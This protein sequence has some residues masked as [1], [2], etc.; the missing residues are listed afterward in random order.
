MKFLVKVTCPHLDC[1]TSSLIKIPS[2][3]FENKKMG[4]IRV[5][6]HAG[7]CCEH[8]FIAFVGKL[9]ANPPKVRGYETIDM[10]IDLSKFIHSHEKGRVYLQDLIQIY[11][12]YAISSC[13]H[14]LMLDC[15]IMFLRSENKTNRAS[16]IATLFNDF[17]PPKY[18]DNSTSITDILEADYK[19]AKINNTLVINPNGLI[20][21]LPWPDISLIFEKKLIQ[22]ALAILDNKLQAVL[23][24][25]DIDILFEKSIFISNIIRK[26]NVFEEDLLQSLSREFHQEISKSEMKLLKQIVEFR[27]K[28]KPNKIKIRSFSKLKEGLW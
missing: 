5:Q 11:G 7:I 6:I 12:D 15:P 20:A 18:Q 13:L 24:T 4:T 17:I 19:K 16:A 14:A 10:A 3:L 8:E 21:N 25:Q 9:K 28:G 2:Y 23:L 1:K 26:N 27:F 22:K